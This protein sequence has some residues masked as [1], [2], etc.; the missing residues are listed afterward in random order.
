MS[1][2][3]DRRLNY[4]FVGFLEPKKPVPQTPNLQIQIVTILKAFG[5][6]INILYAHDMIMNKV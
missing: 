2:C 4:H 3:A 1:S 5:K 6:K